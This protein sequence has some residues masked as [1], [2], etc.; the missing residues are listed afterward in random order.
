VKQVS[1]S[2]VAAVGQLLKGKYTRVT[3]ESQR[4]NI[5]SRVFLF[6]SIHKKMCFAN[7][8]QKDTNRQISHMVSPAVT[9]VH[10]T[11][12]LILQ[13]WL[14]LSPV[15]NKLLVHFVLSVTEWHHPSCSYT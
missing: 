9:A 8:M 6:Y 3:P 15:L 12:R 1:I 13:I 5:F 2:D 4:M 14:Y 7:N 10:L 11:G